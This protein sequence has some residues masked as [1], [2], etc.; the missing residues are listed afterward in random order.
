LL[1]VFL[2]KLRYC[3]LSASF[4]LDKL[5]PADLWGNRPDGERDRNRATV[6]RANLVVR[7]T[8]A[9][10]AA[11][12]ITELLS[13]LQHEHSELEKRVESICG[14]GGSG[15]HGIILLAE[16]PAAT[17]VRSEFDA[18]ALKLGL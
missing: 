13:K 1:A 5:T 4:E 11:G 18:R 8:L 14:P 9:R 15:G 10:G 16:K 7:L 3:Y 12:A 2:F 6:V 17:S